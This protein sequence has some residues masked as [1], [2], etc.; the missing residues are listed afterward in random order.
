MFIPVITIDGPSGSGKGTI[1]RL[2]ANRLGWHYLDSGALYR[3]LACAAQR[4]GVAL[5]DVDGL[6]G[7][8]A[9]IHAE[10]RITADGE[11]SV[12]LDGEPVTG[13]LRTEQSGNAA[14]EIAALPAVRAALLDWQRR[15]REPPGLVADGRDMGTV[16]FPDAALKIFLTASPEERANRRYKQLK[17]MGK[18][19]SLAE[20]MTDV[21]ARDARDRSR[22]ASP[23]AP[24][25]DARLLDNSTLGIEETVARVLDYARSIF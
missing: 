15:Y 24:A 14:S 23:L 16:V 21:R 8:A 25:E 20:I 4:D 18:S 3:L 13:E 17:D 12:L 19:V 11:E 9:R 22:A 1:S 2:L 10:F 6:V 7:L 5:D